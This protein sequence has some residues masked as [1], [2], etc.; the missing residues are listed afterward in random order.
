MIVIFVLP[1]LAFGPGIRFIKKNIFTPSLLSIP[2]ITT[3]MSPM[4]NSVE[5]TTMESSVPRSTKHKGPVIPQGSSSY[6]AGKNHLL[7][8]GIKKVETSID[9]AD[10]FAWENSPDA[11]SDT[12]NDRNS[13][14]AGVHDGIVNIGLPDP[15]YNYPSIPG[16]K[17]PD[18]AGSGI[19]IRGPSF[20]Y[21]LPNAGSRLPAGGSSLPDSGSAIVIPPGTG[22][23]PPSGGSILPDSGS[24]N[25]I[26]PDTGDQP[27]SGG[28][29]PPQ[30]GLAD[31][32]ITG[33]EETPP[34]AGV[35]LPDSGSANSSVPAPVPEPGTLILF[36]SGLLGL[37]VFKR[38]TLRK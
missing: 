23:Q 4:D 27:P 15:Y 20:A 2:T 37:A 28:S 9:V 19:N 38:K 21:L 32:T 36:G 26:P 7:S 29:P 17:N 31:G 6:Q 3:D 11:D 5:I 10:Q 25:D 1:L 35:S 8:P 16:T 33:L 24:A 18:W 30:S 13:H 34:G 22:D 12:N 14:R